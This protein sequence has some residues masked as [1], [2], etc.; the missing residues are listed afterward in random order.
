[1]SFFESFTARFLSTMEKRAAIRVW[2]H[3]QGVDE[4]SLTRAGLSSELLAQGPSAYPWRASQKV[5][6]VGVAPL[7]HN[8]KQLRSAAAELRSF[9]DSEL[10]DLGIARN[11]IDHVV[12]FGRGESENGS[13]Q[14]AA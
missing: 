10:K 5:A 11:S 14:Q 13:S 1:M 3:L 7:A 12:R 2:Y 6:C 8:K 4:Q 9:S